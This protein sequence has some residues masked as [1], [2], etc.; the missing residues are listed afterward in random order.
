MIDFIPTWV[1]I[2][3]L[4]V[5]WQVSYFLFRKDL[6]SRAWVDAKMIHMLACF[7][8]MF[9]T[10]FRNDPRNGW[11]LP[12]FGASLICAAVAACFIKSRPRKPPIDIPYV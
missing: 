1:D 7:V 9:L 8:V 10:I 12:L 11:S 2:V 6:E 5:S 4:V 3:I